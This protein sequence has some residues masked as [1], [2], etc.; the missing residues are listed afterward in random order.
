[1]KKTLLVLLLIL[2]IST[3]SYAIS[4]FDKVVNKEVMIKSHEQRLLVN[5]LTGE[6]KFMWQRPTP[7]RLTGTTLPE[8][9]EWVPLTDE[10]YKKM[11]QDIY[12]RERNAKKQ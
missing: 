4:F 12:D 5:R 9:G 1:M 7:V 2:V 3:P 6:V 11:W 10:N 8:P